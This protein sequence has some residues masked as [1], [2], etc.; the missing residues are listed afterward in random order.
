MSPHEDLSAWIQ[1]Y[2]R[3]WRTAGSDGLGEIFS[4]DAS[5]ATSPFSEP[6]RGLAAISEM[7]EAERLGPDEDFELE[8]EIVAVDGDTGVARIEVRYGPPRDQMYRDL[9]VVV[10]GPDGR[11]TSFEEWPFWPPGTPGAIAGGAS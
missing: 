11:C 4:E 10:T 1:A 9:W 8:S 3:L 2:E 5:Y 7:W 6:L